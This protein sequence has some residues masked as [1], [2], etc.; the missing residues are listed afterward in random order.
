M[1]G[2]PLLPGAI[3]CLSLNE[4]W[5]CGKRRT[6]SRKWKIENMKKSEKEGK[7]ANE[8]ALFLSFIEINGKRRSDTVKIG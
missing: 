1:P 8:A 3:A 7:C 2:L 4:Y 6:G 5:R